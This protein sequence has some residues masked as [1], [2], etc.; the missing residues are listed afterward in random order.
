M[1]NEKL[2]QKRFTFTMS[3]LAILILILFIISLNMGVVR[4]APLDVF[5]TLFGMGSPRDELVLVDF[6]LPRMLLALVIGAALAVSGAILQ[7]VSKNDLADPGILGINTGAG[8]AVILFIYFFQGS[9]NNVSTFGILLMPLFALM[10]AVTAAFLIYALAWKKGIDPVRLILVGIGV[11]SGFGAVIIIFQLKMNPQDFMQAAVWLSGDIWGANWKFVS[12]ISPLILLLLPFAFYK[13][14]VLNLLNLGDQVAIGLGIRVERER[15]FLLLVAVALAGFG[16]AAGGGIAFLGLV[17]PHIAKRLMGPKHQMF[18]PV[19]ALL[20]SL[21]LLVA[22]TLGKNI[23][24]PTEIP[25]GIVVAI[26]S[27]PY[28]IYL[29]MKAK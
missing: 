27:A 10:G 20:G 29:L 23:L 17:A 24:A 16:V 11:N 6:R 2:K 8:F 7:G 9:M 1:N 28:F 4:I 12:I 21:L 14:H 22:D 5:K 19:T 26:L 13:S 18:L 15:R 3:L 25:V